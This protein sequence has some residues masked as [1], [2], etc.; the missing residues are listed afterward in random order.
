ML[1]QI[2]LQRQFQV[3]DKDIMKKLMAQTRFTEQEI[4]NAIDMGLSPTQINDIKQEKSQY[5]LK[6]E[7]LKISDDME[8]NAFRRAL[9]QQNRA[10]SQL[11]ETLPQYSPFYYTVEKLIEDIKS[12]K[13][14]IDQE[15][16]ESVNNAIVSYKDA[17]SQIKAVIEDIRDSREIN[18]NESKALR[19]AGK[20]RLF[21]PK[22]AESLYMQAIDGTVDPAIKVQIEE[23]QKALKADQKYDSEIDGKWGM[24]SRQGLKDLVLENADALI[25]DSN[26][27]QKDQRFEDINKPAKPNRSQ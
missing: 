21:D 16:Q 10:S 9:N 4:Q 24:K 19:I 14:K 23:V 7:D 11:R 1:T 25:L 2:T 8:K 15:Y 27:L 12:N 5:G 22:V 6:R 20:L 3:S 18:T 17:D 13:I 26:Q